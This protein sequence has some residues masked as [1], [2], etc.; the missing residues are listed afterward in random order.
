MTVP[1]ALLT[2]FLGSG[3]TT[4]LRR[5]IK[6]YE[7]RKILYVV[8]EFGNTDVDGIVLSPEGANALT[9]LPGG[10]I[11]CSCLVS[12]F[13]QTLTELL[14]RF[15]TDESPV[16]GVIVEA[17]GVADP[18]VAQ[19]MLHDT[20]LD[21]AYHL[22]AIVALVD[23]GPFPELRHALPAVEAQIKASN[24]VILNKTDLYSAHVLDRTE[25]LIREMQPKAVLWRAVYCGVP[26]GEG[27][28]ELSLL[29]P[30]FLSENAGDYAACADPNFVRLV[31]KFPST[32]DLPKLME[33]L[34][35]LRPQLY[36]AKGFVPSPEGPIHV[37]MSM[38]ATTTTL[39]TPQPA[40]PV[41]VCIG[42][43]GS[44]EALTYLSEQ[45]KKGS[46]SA[47]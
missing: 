23:P 46:F 22:G 31:L 47:N 45:I 38:A 37:D 39:E 42:R 11:F 40:A 3:K 34:E 5:V 35:E 8:N 29:R 36:R 2:G 21:D 33:A 14:W 26:I 10:S 27:K 9:A 19:R 30:A 28:G 24:A 18:L 17:S 32:V 13:T 1:L 43:R 4:L 15:Q 44:F 7:N 12:E 41:L 16:E 6:A 25:T 20:H